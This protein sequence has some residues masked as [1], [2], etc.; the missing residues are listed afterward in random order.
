MSNRKNSINYIQNK[1]GCTRLNTDWLQTGNVSGSLLYYIANNPEKQEKLREEVMSVLPDKTSPVT[2]DVLNQTRY[3]KACI[4]E[5]LR[6]SPL[7]VANLRTMQTDVCIGGYRIPAGVRAIFLLLICYNWSYNWNLRLIRYQYLI[8]D[9]NI[10]T[11]S[12]KYLKNLW[13]KN[14]LRKIQKHS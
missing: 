2:Q 5:S 6:L 8:N 9:Y 10:C 7:S 12:S 3:T 1:W 13:M 4:K 14:V 11:A